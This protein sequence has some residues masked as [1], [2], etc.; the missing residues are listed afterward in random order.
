MSSFVVAPRALQSLHCGIVHEIR[1]H[2]WSMRR[3]RRSGPRR[4][5]RLDEQHDRH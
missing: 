1:L 3:L 4:A 2:R 5:H